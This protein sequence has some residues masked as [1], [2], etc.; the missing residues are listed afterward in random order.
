MKLLPAPRRSINFAAAAS[1]SQPQ[2]RSAA[3]PLLAAVVESELGGARDN[4]AAG[5]LFLGLDALD[6]DTIMKRAEMHELLLSQPID[7]LRLGPNRALSWAT[8]RLRRMQKLVEV[9]VMAWSV[10]HVLSPSTAL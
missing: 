4:N 6:H 7:V 10:V 2:P 9:I 1:R 8:E 3:P 5:G